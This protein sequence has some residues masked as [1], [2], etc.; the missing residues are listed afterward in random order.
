MATEGA[1]CLPLRWNP[2]NKGLPA[3]QQITTVSRWAELVV[4]Q[5]THCDC[6]GVVD[7]IGSV[8]HVLSKLI[9]S[10]TTVPVASDMQG[11]CAVCWY[12]LIC[13]W[14]TRRLCIDTHQVWNRYFASRVSRCCCQHCQIH[15]TQVNKYALCV[16][17]NCNSY[18]GPCNKSCD[19]RLQHQVTGT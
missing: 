9:T 1:D 15:E 7:N 12:T 18:L 11:I 17:C 6:V 5:Q 4:L 13:S 14:L 19:S 3:T 10:T 2:Q 16:M 8:H